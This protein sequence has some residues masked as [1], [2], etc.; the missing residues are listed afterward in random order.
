MAFLVNVLIIVT[1]LPAIR[2][3]RDH[4]RCPTRQNG[5]DKVVRIIRPVGNDLLTHKIGQQLMS[6]SNVMPLATGQ[7]ETQR[8]AQSIHA[9]VDFGAEATSAA[10]QGLRRLSAVFFDAPAALG[11]ARTMVLSSIRCSISGSSAKYASIRCQMSLSHQRA[12]RLYTLFHA[13]YSLGSN[14]HCAPLLITHSTPS[15]KRRHSAGCPTYMSGHVR[16]NPSIFD[17]WSSRNLTVSIR[18]LST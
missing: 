18:P 1:R 14:R 4:R 15:T 12:N 3:G 5:L 16:R 13:P 10:S 11:W 7:S 17:H 8:V 6:L 2:A 9:H